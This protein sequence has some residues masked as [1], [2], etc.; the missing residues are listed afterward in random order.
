MVGEVCSPNG[1]VGGAV[2]LDSEK[3]E[4]RTKEEE[5]SAEKENETV[6]SVYYRQ[7][8]Q[9]PLCGMK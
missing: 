9:S 4:T 1:F 7:L 8:I 6:H 5:S 2:I 3:K